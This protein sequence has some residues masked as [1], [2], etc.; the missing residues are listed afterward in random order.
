MHGVSQSAVRRLA[1]DLPHVRGQC[2]RW[3]RWRSG[4]GYGASSAML[5]RLLDAMPSTLCPRCHGH[6]PSCMLCDG[7]GRIAGSLT[8]A[9]LSRRRVCHACKG[10][11]EVG[12]RTCHRC[13]GSGWRT[14]VEMAVNP[15]GISSTRSV[16]GRDTTPAAIRA[17][18]DQVL[19]WQRGSERSFALVLIWEYT[20]NGT[21]AMKAGRL[22]ISQ[23]TFSRKL[24][25]AHAQI[26][27]L[28]RDC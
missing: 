5:G 17:I 8:P 9:S 22:R 28:L 15:A 25:E 12:E 4:F 1:V 24:A 27:Q 19:A 21:Q 10:I 16:G 7:N 11:G 6:N 3:A 13:R 23:Q 2:E 26:D 18:E 14:L 20:R